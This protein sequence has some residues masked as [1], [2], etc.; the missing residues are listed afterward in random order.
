MPG[1]DW[2]KGKLDSVSV[3]SSPR[4]K[5]LSRKRRGQPKEPS[6][7]TMHSIGVD[8][9]P[10][11]PWRVENVRTQGCPSETDWWKDS[12]KKSAETDG[13]GSKGGEENGET[14]SV[15][16]AEFHNCG[17]ETWEA[18]RKQWRAAKVKEK[19]PHPPPVRYDEVVRGLTQVVR[20]YEL[21]DRMTLPD[22]IEVFVDIWECEKDY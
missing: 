22:I 18:A 17:F 21:P 1:Y 14:C 3:P 13:G 6:S 10:D 5:M 2:L 11:A 19:R 8:A 7:L 9:P 20:T 4:K 12:S 16:G 15:A